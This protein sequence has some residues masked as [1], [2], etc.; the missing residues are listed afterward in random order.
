MRGAVRFVHVAPFPQGVT[1]YRRARGR[2]RRRGGGGRLAGQ[3]AAPPSSLARHPPAA[4]PVAARAQ[5]ASSA[6]ATGAS[7]AHPRLQVACRVVAAADRTPSAAAAAYG[8]SHARALW[9]AQYKYAH[10]DPPQ[11][12]VWAAVVCGA[13]HFLVTFNAVRYGSQIAR[14]CLAWVC[15]MEGAGGILCSR[16]PWDSWGSSSRHVWAQ[17]G[18]ACAAAL[19]LT[20]AAWACLGLD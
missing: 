19:G 11:L 6:A 15:V 12:L 14:D 10:A 3:H 16:T 20:G 17:R 7:R 5:S 4:V 1:R 2:G 9:R 13:L 18:S 8:G